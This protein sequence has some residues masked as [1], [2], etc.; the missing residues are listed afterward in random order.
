M[1]RTP[2]TKLVLAFVDL[3]GVELTGGWRDRLK[4]V[5]ETRAIPQAKAGCW[6]DN[7][8][9][10]MRQLLEH[11]A[12]E[13]T[14]HAWMGWYALPYTDDILQVARARALADYEKLT[15]PTKAAGR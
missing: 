3:D 2:K 7:T 15:S 10:R 9:D 1:T 8:A 13:R 14:H 11:I 6:S 5:A 4:Q 12:K